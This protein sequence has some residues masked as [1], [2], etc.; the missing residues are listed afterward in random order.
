[1]NFGNYINVFGYENNNV[2]P[3]RINKQDYENTIDLLLTSKTLVDLF[4]LKF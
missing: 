2:Y 4:L 1:M 3:L